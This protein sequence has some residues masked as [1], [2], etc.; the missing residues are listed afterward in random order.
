MSSLDFHDAAR[1]VAACIGAQLKAARRHR[2]LTQEQFAELVGYS[3]AHVAS[4]EQGRRTPNRQY[5]ATADTVLNT[6][7]IFS[8]AE[9]LLSAASVVGQ[10]TG[11]AGVIAPVARHRY[12]VQVVGPLLRT[13]EYARALH[14]M[15]RPYVPE[16][17]VEERL[18]TEREGARTLTE[19]SGTHITCVVQESV[20]Q[21]PYGGRDVLRGQLEH[22]LRLGSFRNVELQVMPTAAT[23]HPGAGGPVELIEIFAGR[24]VAYLPSTHGSTLV[25]SPKKVA[26]LQSFYSELRAQAL[27]TGD[28]LRVIRH[29]L[30]ALDS[31]PESAPE[32]TP[33]L[34]STSAPAP[35]RALVPAPV[36]GV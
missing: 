34:A 14:G 19:D 31:A 17:I 11:F 23:Y 9:A 27:P 16:K 32:S 10:S 29:H 5:L 8:A 33:A 12:D 30:A 18:A 22:L 21:S 28:S 3:A 7:G 25:A 24:A 36:P 26:R 35:P 2:G 1:A 4:V 6:G 13:E 20:L 15:R